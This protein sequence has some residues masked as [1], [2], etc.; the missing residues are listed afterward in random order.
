MAPESID[1]EKADWLPDAR[2][3][4]MNV[5][6]SEFEDCYPERV[7]AA[8]FKAEYDRIW[9]VLKKEAAERLITQNP[10]PSSGGP[11]RITLPEGRSLF[12][13]VSKY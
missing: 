5:I 6:E 2:K 9:D 8:D 13:E 12:R 10:D 7:I 4:V 3:R 1:P 11:V